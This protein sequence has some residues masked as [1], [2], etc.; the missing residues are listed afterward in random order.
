MGATT[1]KNNSIYFT[2]QLEIRSKRFKAVGTCAEWKK[3]GGTSLIRVNAVTLVDGL[4]KR[5]NERK[6]LC[7]INIPRLVVFFLTRVS[8]DEPTHKSPVAKVD[9]K[10][11]RGERELRHRAKLNKYD[12]MKTALSES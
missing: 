9:H 7:I 6:Q 8:N 4:K 10:H 2:R 11:A 5:M 12:E 3:K 1:S